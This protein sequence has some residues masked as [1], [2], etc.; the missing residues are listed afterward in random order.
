MH[1]GGGVGE[2][3]ASLQVTVSC[4]SRKSTLAQINKPRSGVN[5]LA[6]CDKQTGDLFTEYVE[7]GPGMMCLRN[8]FVCL[9]LPVHTITSA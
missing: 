3:G 4:N 5:S 1:A 7:V 2:K 8:S 9:R 6:F